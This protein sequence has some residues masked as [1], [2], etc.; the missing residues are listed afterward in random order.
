MRIFSYI[1]LFIILIL[2]LTFAALNATPVAFDYYVGNRNISLS[3]LLVYTLGVGIILGAIAALGPIFRLKR[4]NMRLKGRVK[5]A[6]KEIEN[7]RAIP[8]KDSH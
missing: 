6:E 3:L 4:Q 5:E 1:I 2:G 8:I 7:L